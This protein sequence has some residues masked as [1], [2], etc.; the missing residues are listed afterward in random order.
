[1]TFLNLSACH[2]ADAAVESALALAP[3]PANTDVAAPPMPV[4]APAASS[5]SSVPIGAIAG[6]TIGTAGEP[7][8]C[9]LISRD[10]AS[11]VCPIHTVTSVA[12]SLSVVLALLAFLARRYKKGRLRHRQPAMAGVATCD[13]DKATLKLSIAELD[14]FWQ[15]EDTAA[16]LKESPI[17]TSAAPLNG[18]PARWA[19]VVPAAAR[20]PMHGSSCM[21]Y[22]VHTVPRGT[23]A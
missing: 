13:S 1:M 2:L 22:S 8:A 3:A 15:S 20:I 23:P 14:T 18:Y 17:N 11:A 7:P 9:L 10:T 19:P 16:S 4:A 6:G 12:A 5:S 21:V